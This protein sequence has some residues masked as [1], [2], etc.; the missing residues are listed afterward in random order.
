MSKKYLVSVL[1]SLCC[2]MV[3]AAPQGLPD[4]R[5]VEQRNAAVAFAAGR[6]MTLAM[7]HRACSDV[8][9]DVTPSISQV[10]LQWLERNHLE[11]EASDAWLRRYFSYLKQNDPDLA[12]SESTLLAQEQAKLVSHAVDLHFRRSIPTKDSCA[13]AARS[14]GVPQLDIKNL[15]SASGYESFG[16][17]A[18]TLK[19][20]RSEPGFS[21]LE[22]PRKRYENLIE[23][24][25]KRPSQVLLVAADAAGDRGDERL[26]TSIFEKMASQGDAKA[27]QT[28]A[29]AYHRGGGNLSQDLKRAYRWFYLAWALGDVDGL[30]GLGV[31]IKEGQGIARDPALAFATF[32]VVKAAA[33]SE[34][35]YLRAANNMV[36]LESSVPEATRRILACV[37]IGTLDAKLEGLIPE[38]GAPM[39]KRVL[40]E[41][42]RRLGE[43][44]K[45]LAPHYSRDAC[46]RSDIGS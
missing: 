39:L 34:P 3:V 16:E 44:S 10:A 14:Y 31:M 17:F 24:T 6:E 13:S 22:S 5:E 33:E 21:V 40:H 46:T 25:A 11:L 32:S 19:R 9:A 43:L 27:A 26:R 36:A 30:N 2:S 35:T 37:S 15:K 20:I 23:Q 42:G 12:K 29:L 7:I 1:C 8:L 4:A 28:V 41:P 18:E 45:D 38:Q